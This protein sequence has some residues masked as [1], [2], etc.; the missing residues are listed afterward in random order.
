MSSPA[1]SNDVEGSSS[2][3][4]A[5]RV[6]A[7]STLDNHFSASDP[8]VGDVGGGFPKFSALPPELRILIWEEVHGREPGVVLDMERVESETQDEDGMDFAPPPPVL[9]R[10]CRESRS[11]ALRT[12]RSFVLTYEWRCERTG[13]KTASLR[14]W[15]DGSRDLLR[16]SVNR[17]S[18]LVR[19]H[20]HPRD[21]AW[22]M[23][24][25]LSD[26]LRL[27]EH[28]LLDDGLPR[29]L[30]EFLLKPG[31]CAGLKTMSFILDG[32]PIEARQ[33]HVSNPEE[34]SQV[35]RVLQFFGKD[36]M[37]LIDV[38]DIINIRQMETK[39]TTRRMGGAFRN[40]S[41]ARGPRLFVDQYPFAAFREISNEYYFPSDTMVPQ[42]TGVV[43]SKWLAVYRAWE[44]ARGICS[45]EQ[46]EEKI[47]LE[48][49]MRRI[50][51]QRGGKSGV[52]KVRYVVCVTYPYADMDTDDGPTRRTW[53]FDDGWL[54]R[55]LEQRGPN[56]TSN[57]W[58]FRWKE[59]TLFYRYMATPNMRRL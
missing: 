10:V 17:Q 4:A 14:T 51:W 18:N 58:R 31:L 57:E 3:M 34:L 12:G 26:L 54:D 50:T 45:T 19:T 59:E 37:V 41:G 21:R 43:G 23:T 22:V 5:P 27:T 56:P 53:R 25:E 20:G 6:F 36:K 55:I 35:D 13:R 32:W 38:R 29:I 28:I 15:F 24:D 7:Q 11:V 49:L 9:S 48:K 40:T 8:T 52:T 2:S 16:F 47:P 33:V 44:A 39:D 1:T 42:T 30:L 46:E